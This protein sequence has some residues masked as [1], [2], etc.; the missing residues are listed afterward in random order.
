MGK[1][2]GKWWRA[3][4]GLKMWKS[5][6]KKG[7][8]DGDLLRDLLL[9]DCCTSASVFNAS[10]GGFLSITDVRVRIMAV[11]PLFRVW[12]G[13]PGAFGTLFW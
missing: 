6:R 8:V 4:L 10:C 5:Q 13:F 12:E 7:G 3:I 9:F 2:S 1:E 11:V